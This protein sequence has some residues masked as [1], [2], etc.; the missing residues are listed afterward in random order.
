M[1]EDAWQGRTALVTGGDGFI[2]ANLVRALRAR[3]ASVHVLRR[4]TAPGSRLRALGNDVI[5]HQTDITDAAR[6]AAVVA[7]VRPHAV[8]HLAA[9]GTASD[10]T[11]PTRMLR[12]NV[13]GTLNLLLALQ[14]L[15]P[16]TF[17]NTGTSAEYRASRRPL[18]ESSALGP[19]TTYG[20]TKA[21]AD[22][23]CAAA[24]AS[25]PH[26]IVTLR[27]FHVYGPLDDPRRLVPTAMRAL[28]TG[29]PIHLVR[30]VSRRDF[31]YID[32][33]VDAYLRAAIRRPGVSGHA[34]NVGSGRQYSLAEA[35]RLLGRLADHQLKILRG[36]FPA[37]PWDQRD[38]AAAIGKA[39]R[40]LGW[41]PAYS[42]REGLFR[43][44][45]WY[46]AGA[47]GLDQP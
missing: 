6:V 33:V 9:Y 34:F 41:K 47:E 21:S 15:L 31:I 22:I 8:F 14:P 38:W 32:D 20:V 18:Q 29:E 17:V 3:G 12:T 24:A 42:L 19:G 39:H 36:G 25:S 46:R 1:A 44:L 4:G 2:G 28:L 35:L 45:A 40:L 43:T 16:A 26:Q 5:S 13:E 30:G 27:L 10:H 37:R 23:L 11:D 7:D